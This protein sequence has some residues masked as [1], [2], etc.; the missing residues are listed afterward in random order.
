[1]REQIGERSEWLRNID[2]TVRDLLIQYGTIL[3]TRENI[4]LQSRIGRLTWVLIGLTILIIMLTAMSLY[5]STNPD[6]AFWPWS[7]DSHSDG[8]GIDSQSA[9]S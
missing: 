3:G 1:M 6:K 9:G 2:R 7:V 5:V 4:N 8:R